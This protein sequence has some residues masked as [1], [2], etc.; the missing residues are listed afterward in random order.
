LMLKDSS[1]I[2]YSHITSLLTGIGK[3][4]SIMWISNDRNY[5]HTT[6]LGPDG[7]VGVCSRP[8]QATQLPFLPDTEEARS[9][10]M[11]DA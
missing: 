10:F 9:A 8:F 11:E 2:M 1:L 5:H 4:N 3:H 7:T 6:E